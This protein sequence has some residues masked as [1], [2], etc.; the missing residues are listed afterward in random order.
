MSYFLK[1][2]ELETERLYLRQW[3]ESD[4]HP[5]YLINSNP[6]VMRYFPN[7]LTEEEN[8]AAVDRVRAHIETH[9]WGFWAVELKETGKLAGFV[10]LNIPTY[11]LPF[12][13]CVEIGWRLSPEYW[14]KG[15]ATEAGKTCLEFAFGTLNLNEIVSFTSVLNTPSEA[16]MKRLGMKNANANFFNPVVP[17]E[18]PLSEHV[19]Y[20]VEK[21]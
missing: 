17:K 16:V 6:E 8:N 19:L 1:I 3:K 10:G 9:G 20:K 11:E 21:G 4:K 18:S 15:Y 2:Y 12:S 5:L 7:L 14:G 13:P